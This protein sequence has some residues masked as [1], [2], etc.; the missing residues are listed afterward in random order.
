MALEPHPD[1]TNPV[2]TGSDVTDISAKYVADPFLYT[3]SGMDW[4]MF[5][6]ANPGSGSGAIAH[7][8]SPDGTTW[9][10]DQA[11][12]QKSY[13]IS[14]PFVIK[15]E[16]SDEYYLI[17]SRND[18]GAHSAYRATNFPTGW[19]VD[20]DPFIEGTEL[21]GQGADASI[22]QWDGKWWA[23]AGS[24]DDGSYG[25][26]NLY[27]YYTEGGLLSGSWQSHSNNPV[28]ANNTDLARPAGRI[29]SRSDR[30]YLPV[31]Q[32]APDYG[33]KTRLI[34]VTELSPTSFSFTEV[35]TSPI[36]E[37]GGTGWRENGMHHLDSWWIGDR[38]LCA[39]DGKNSSD[40]W[41]IGIY[42]NTGP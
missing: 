27:A 8:T 28:I 16:D 19:T 22:V 35:S 31:Q 9:T 42:Q 2:L 24:N 6:E 5:F 20:T 30:F 11:I 21:D 41:S 26:E 37:N 38:W 32:T 39:V 7:A 12:I 23:F 13:Q 40:N 10:Y 29:Y 4:H 25:Y 17:F 14:Y 18:S 34:E 36:L 3:E 33:I 15:D 1:V